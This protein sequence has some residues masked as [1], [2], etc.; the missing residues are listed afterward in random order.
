MS[1]QSGSTSSRKNKYIFVNYHRQLKT[2]N[3]AAEI[4]ES[5]IQWGT[6]KRIRRKAAGMMEY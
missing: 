4:I 3:K 6:V 2:R 5:T 1:S